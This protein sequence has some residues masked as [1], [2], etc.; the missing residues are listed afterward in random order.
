MKEEEGSVEEKHPISVWIAHG[1]GSDTDKCTLFY[2][3]SPYVLYPAVFLGPVLLWGYRFYCSC[4]ILIILCFLTRMVRYLYG[5]L[6]NM[7]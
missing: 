7:G 5:L 3:L 6:A 2:Y 1:Y 4:A